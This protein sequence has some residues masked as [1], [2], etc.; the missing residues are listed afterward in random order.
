MN[1]GNLRL[2]ERL[3]ADSPDRETAIVELRALLMKALHSGLSGRAGADHAFI[4]DVT[5]MALLKILDKLDS[6]KGLSQFSSW[7]I[8]IAIRTAF[9]QLRRKE[10]K[11]ISLEELRNGNGN[12]PGEVDHSPQ[13]V[14]TNARSQIEEVMLRLIRTEL[15]PR[16]RDVL[17]MELAEV[18]QDQIVK[19]LGSNRNAV[20]K[21]FHDA[22]KSLKRALEAHGYGRQDIAELYSET[23]RH[24]LQ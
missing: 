21:L 18:P 14:E 3:A 24:F 23:S 22:R 16:Q 15:T 17:L 8:T 1:I 11:Q 13:P 4:E 9:T 2:E 19:I 7:A 6:F 5:Q 20:Y 12:L 10:W